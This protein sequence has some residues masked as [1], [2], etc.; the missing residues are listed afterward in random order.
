MVHRLV[1]EAFLDNP[2]NKP[3]VDHVNGRRADNRLENLRFSDYHEQALNK[4]NLDELSD[5]PWLEYK[6]TYNKKNRERYY[7]HKDAYNKRKHEAYLAHR[8]ERI[9]R[10]KQ[11]WN[12]HKE[13]CKASH[14]Q[15]YLDN[16][17]RCL[18]QMKDNYQKRKQA[19]LSTKPIIVVEPDTTTD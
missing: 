9:E 2:E 13:A 11:Y 10:Q 18:Q 4:H 12:S 8:E 3:T 17:E 1:A 16:R 14:Q 6:D 7:T 5:E 15:W 19:K